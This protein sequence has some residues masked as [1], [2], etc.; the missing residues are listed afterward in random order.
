MNWVFVA[1]IA[2]CVS[3]VAA[4]R[5]RR[6]RPADAEDAAATDGRR[7]AT[8]VVRAGDANAAEAAATKRGGGEPGAEGAAA[9]VGR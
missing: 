9:E 1:T 2:V 7:G 5:V 8:G 3:L 4:V 6:G